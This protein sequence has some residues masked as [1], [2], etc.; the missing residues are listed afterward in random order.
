MQSPQH[1]EILPGSEESVTC[2]V[3][4]AGPECEKR[5]KLSFGL[6]IVIRYTDAGSS[7][8][9]S[10]DLVGDVVDIPLQ[11]KTKQQTQPKSGQRRVVRA[12]H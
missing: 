2:R 12:K 3:A 6:R 1:L 4:I 11:P 10:Q 9:Y 7:R 8:Q 5:T